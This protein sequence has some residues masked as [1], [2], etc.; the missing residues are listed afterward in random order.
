V[1]CVAHEDYVA[2]R[3]EPSFERACDEQGPT[4]RL[5][6]HL[7]DVRDPGGWS[8]TLISTR[9][10][11]SKKC[12]VRES[13]ATHIGSKSVYVFLSVGRASSS[14]CS[15]GVSQWCARTMLNTSPPEIGYEMTLKV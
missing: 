10:S 7:A 2:P 3:G 8:F 6:D 9:N 4:L 11:S 13:E 12:L 1:G 14:H 15:M 5:G